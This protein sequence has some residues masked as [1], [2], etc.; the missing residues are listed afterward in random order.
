MSDTHNP[1]AIV[2]KTVRDEAHPWSSI[3]WKVLND[4]RLN[5]QDR[6]TMVYL[7]GHGND[8]WFTVKSLARDMRVDESTTRNSLKRLEAFGYVKRTRLARSGG[9]FSPYM[10][11]VY[12]DP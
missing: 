10:W 9:Q 11:A 1:P 3:S 5:V 12:E 8:W 2:Q 7:L 6:L 4:T